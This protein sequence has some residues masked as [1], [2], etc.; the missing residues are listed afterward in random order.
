MSNPPVYLL[1]GKNITTAPPVNILT[2]GKVNIGST[3][4]TI[5]TS[6]N[7]IISTCSLGVGAPNV[8][9]GI[10]NYG[11]YYSDGVSATQIAAD[12]SNNRP[13][14]K[15]GY[16]RYNTE[17]NIIE[18]W[19]VSFLAW[20][21]IYEP[22]PLVVNANPTRI[23]QGVQRV[24]TITGYNFNISS[25]VTFIGDVDGIYGP[26][27]GTTF[28]NS[29]TLQATN[30][31]AMAD[32]SNNTG[33]FVKVLNTSS[34]TSGI[35]STP[36]IQ[37][38]SGPQWT[39]AAGTNLGTGIEG[40]TYTLDPST[41]PFTA[42]LATDANTPVTYI[43]SVA[44]N[45]G[46]T[47]TLDPSSG[48]IY[49]TMPTNLNSSVT[50]TFIALAQD[51]FGALS[52]L[53]S[54]A[55]TV[56]PTT[57]TLVSPAGG[58]TS[59][60]FTPNLYS[61]SPFTIPFASGAT[62]TN[63]AY[64]LSFNSDVSLNMLLKGGDG[65]GGFVYPGGN[66]PSAPLGGGGGWAY[67]QFRF[68]KNTQYRLLIGG[69]GTYQGQSLG[70]GPYVNGGGGLAG[71]QG[72]GGQG[73]GETGLFS[74]GTIAQANTLLLASGG[75]GAA[76]EIYYYTAQLTPGSSLQVNGYTNGGSGGD[77]TGIN[78]LTSNPFP[79]NSSDGTSGGGGGGGGGGGTQSAG[80]AGA[81]AGIV[82]P[83]NPGFP[84]SAL[85]GGN[86]GNSGDGGGGGGGGGGY[87]GGGSGSGANPGSSGGGGSS[88]VSGSALNGM[89][90]GGIP[91]TPESTN[92]QPGYAKLYYSLSQSVVVTYTGGSPLPTPSSVN[93]SRVY[94]FTAPV[95]TT[96]SYTF[97]INYPVIVA[98]LCVAG[99]GSGGGNGG[100]GGGGGGFLQGVTTITAGTNITISV[101]KGG[102]STTPAGAV[103][104]T[105]NN[106]SI[107]GGITTTITSIGGGGGG[108]SSVNGGAT[109]GGCG[110]G[111]GNGS[112]FGVN[113]SCTGG[114][115]TQGQGYSGGFGMHYSGEFLGGGGGGGAG[116]CGSNLG[117]CAYNA[118]TPVSANSGGTGGFGLTSAITGSAVGYAGGGGGGMNGN[119]SG[120]LAPGWGGGGTT[121][122]LFGAGNGGRLNDGGGGIFRSPIAGQANTGG[123]GGGGNHPSVQIGEAGGSGIVVI[124]MPLVW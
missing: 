122:N 78:G 28:V 89:S 119:T 111:G 104:N 16:I 115:G 103:G 87:F 69:G 85:T 2:N 112:G 32:A 48:K 81:T 99:G 51:S 8:P 74:S 71:V 44:P 121:G 67:S 34:G 18:Y 1:P 109:N 65:G 63:Y 9:T 106:S 15:A 79:N 77:L 39:T 4:D 12:T 116:G 21:A 33:F 59:G 62:I 114:L 14:G 118:T 27:S 55:F 10:N 42:I 56:V 95:N 68:T 5:I 64:T 61:S 86:C 24:Y 97:R 46:T 72:F 19:N 53:R 120:G 17:S 84:G 76:F 20:L 6:N 73:G 41:N 88:Y 117:P 70:T 43:Y 108:T 113:K 25:V 22:S 54:F 31:L 94:S 38:N 107:S 11:T 57:Y 7:S 102:S 75:G 124:R 100:G 26:L 40:E 30:S 92:G 90:V 36:L 80:G 47:I 91:T 23:D 66:Q 45:T 35:S 98:Y 83:S 101:G 3:S 58:T 93:G 13:Y 96:T 110:G 82:Y 29:G 52:V 50:Y 60:F 105:G 123:G 49:G 37:Y